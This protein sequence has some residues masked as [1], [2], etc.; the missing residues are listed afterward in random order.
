MTVTLRGHHKALT[1]PLFIS[2]FFRPPHHL[3][4]PEIQL[5]T[6]AESEWRMSNGEGEWGHYRGVWIGT[7]ES[8]FVQHSQLPLTLKCAAH[9]T[10]TRMAFLLISAPSFW[11]SRRW[12]ILRRASVTFPSKLDGCNVGNEGN[13]MFSAYRFSSSRQRKR[14]RG[15]NVHFLWGECKTCEWR[16]NQG[17]QDMKVSIQKVWWCLITW[18]WSWLVYQSFKFFSCTN[19]VSYFYFLL[20][21]EVLSSL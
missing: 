12:S 16:R 2:S 8:S 17:W 15:E 10:L 14:L 4:K 11:S 1:K 19:C 13:E 7:Q 6:P 3:H 5:P 20:L 9:L 21:K 18:L